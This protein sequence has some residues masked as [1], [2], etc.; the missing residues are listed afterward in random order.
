M[1]TMTFGL[2]E[3]MLTTKSSRHREGRVL[4]S[5]VSGPVRLTSTLCKEDNKYV[6]GV[7]HDGASV[8]CSGIRT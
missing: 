4:N 8:V 5:Y 1:Y 2:K 7:L 3:K 6:N